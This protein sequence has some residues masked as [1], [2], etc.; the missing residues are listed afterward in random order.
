MSI[1][2]KEGSNEKETPREHLVRH[3]NEST[4]S[5]SPEPATNDESKDKGKALA[6]G[7]K[8]DP[9]ELQYDD[10]AAQHN[11]PDHAELCD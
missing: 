2:N 3:I 5:K 4:K 7:W 11:L 10:L 1:D 6:C 8:G 9:V